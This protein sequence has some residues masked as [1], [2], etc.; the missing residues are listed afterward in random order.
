MRVF[1]DPDLCEGHSKC[2]KAAPQVFEVDDDDLSHVL[3]DPVP[4][5]Y[6]EGVEQAV[7]LCPRAAIS[8]TEDE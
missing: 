4:E 1:V 5:E 7:R 2:E 8:M 3:M 6:R